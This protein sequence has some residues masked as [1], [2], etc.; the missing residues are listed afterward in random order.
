MRPENLTGALGHLFKIS[1]EIWYQ[2]GD[3][4]LDSSWYTK[5]FILTN[6]YVATELYMIQDKSRGQEATWEF[7]D[8]RIEDVMFMG[9]NINQS[10]NFLTAVG[11]GIGSIA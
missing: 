10:S 9:A 3:K 6:L 2:A 1:D 11:S 7:L 5:R 8:R 4:S